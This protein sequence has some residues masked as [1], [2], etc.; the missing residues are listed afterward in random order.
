MSEY[1]ETTLEDMIPKNGK[2]FDEAQASRLA[3]QVLQ[4][5]RYL[6]DNELEA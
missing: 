4:A 1:I 5:I 6:H 3:G 2:G